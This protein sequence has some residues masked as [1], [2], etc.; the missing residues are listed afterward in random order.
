MPTVVQMASELSI[1]KPC[2]QAMPQG[3]TMFDR[4]GGEDF[5]DRL[6]RLVYEAVS[7]DPVLRPL[8]PHDAEA[9][10]AARVHLKLFLM[11]FWG[12][13][14]LYRAERGDPRLRQRHAPFAIGQAERDAW[15]EHISEAVKSLGLSRL[16]ETQMISYL[17][18][19]ATHMINQG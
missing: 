2:W 19:A 5:F 7:N 4:V 13:P 8:Y 14:D 11:Q 18:N 3:S 1:D 10:E 15:V 16:D 9:F 17:S 12:G 6:T